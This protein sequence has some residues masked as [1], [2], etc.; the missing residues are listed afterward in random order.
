MDPLTP[1]QEAV[2]AFIRREI[3]ERKLPPTSR[4]VAAHFGFNQTAA[5][6]HINRIIK[7]GHLRKDGRTRGL[8]LVE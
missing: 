8:Y 4:E 3:E 5:I 1:R 2:L 6:N 7:K